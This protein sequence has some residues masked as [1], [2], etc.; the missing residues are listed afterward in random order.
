MPVHY[1][2]WPQDGGAVDMTEE[3]GVRDSVLMSFDRMVQLG[4]EGDTAAQ[5]EM[6]AEA[7]DV[8]SSGE[9]SGNRGGSSMACQADDTQQ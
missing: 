7:E 2:L 6:E 4:M 8:W 9:R 5:A 3:S 1:A